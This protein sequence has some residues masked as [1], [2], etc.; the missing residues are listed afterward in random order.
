MNSKIFEFFKIQKFLSLMQI[1]NF[2]NFGN[3]WKQDMKSISQ[4]TNSID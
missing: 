2:Y 3:N 4:S 1:Q